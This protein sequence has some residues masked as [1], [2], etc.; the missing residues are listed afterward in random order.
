MVITRYTKWGTLPVL[1]DCKQAYVYGLRAEGATE[2]KYIGV[3][4]NP[5]QR[6][7]KHFSKNTSPQKIEWIRSVGYGYV[8]MV[9][10]VKAEY[11][12]AL[13]IER[14][15]IKFYGIENLLNCR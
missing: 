13:R 1:Q 4:I 10:L 12:D 6:L 15:L 3:T 5:R 7:G 8:E 14:E 11:L 2:F 9:V